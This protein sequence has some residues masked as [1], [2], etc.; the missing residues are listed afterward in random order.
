MDVDSEGDEFFPGDAPGMQLYPPDF[1]PIDLILGA[2]SNREARKNPYRRAFHTMKHIVSPEFLA[3]RTGGGGVT[4]AVKNGVDEEVVRRF[5]SPS[6]MLQSDARDSQEALA[7][8]RLREPFHPFETQG[9][10]AI[11]EWAL[12]SG[13][14]A[15]A[16]SQLMKLASRHGLWSVRSGLSGHQIAS[17]QALIA[18][19]DAGI[20]IHTAQIELR[21]NGRVYGTRRFC[22]IKAEDSLHQMLRDPLFADAMHVGPRVLL[23]SSGDRFISDFSSALLAEELQ[24]EEGPD[25]ALVWLSA[26]SDSSVVN[27]KVSIYP[28]YLSPMN[29]AKEARGKEGAIRLSGFMPSVSANELRNLGVADSRKATVLRGVV[30]QC[31]ALVHKGLTT[32]QPGWAQWPDKRWRLTKGVLVFTKADGKEA[33]C[34]SMTATKC[35]ECNVRNLLDHLC[36]PVGAPPLPL[37]EPRAIFDRLRPLLAEWRNADGTIRWGGQGVLEKG[38]KKAGVRKEWMLGDPA[39]RPTF[40]TPPC[41]MHELGHGMFGTLCRDYCLGL[42]SVYGYGGAMSVCTRLDERGAAHPRCYGIRTANREFWVLMLVKAGGGAHKNGSRKFQ[43][44]EVVELLLLTSDTLRASC[45]PETAALRA[46]VA[47]GTATWNWRDAESAG[48]STDSSAVYDIS[49]DVFPLL[50]QLLHWAMAVK[51]PTVTSPKLQMLLQQTHALQLEYHSVFEMCTPVGAAF[52]K[53][54]R[55]VHFITALLLY[56]PAVGTSTDQEE[57]QHVIFK[58]L[59]WQT[60][61]HA[62][63]DAQ[64]MKRYVLAEKAAEANGSASSQPSHCVT[65]IRSHWPLIEVCSYRPM[66]DSG[67]AA[68]PF[69]IKATLHSPC[70]RDAAHVGIGNALVL[71]TLANRKTHPFSDL[72]PGLWGPTLAAGA[73]PRGS[74][75]N[76]FATKISRF[77]QGEPD[78]ATSAADV[79]PLYKDQIVQHKTLVLTTTAPW[80]KPAALHAHHD[81]YGKRV[82]S[83]VLFRPSADITDVADMWAAHLLFLGKIEHTPEGAIEEAARRGLRMPTRE[84]RSVAYVQWFEE[85]DAAP[86]DAAAPYLPRQFRRNASPGGHQVVDVDKIVGEI[87]MLPDAVAPH[88]DA[89]QAETDVG[90]PRLIPLFRLNWELLHYWG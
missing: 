14:G 63:Y 29:I 72:Y 88:R 58:K 44:N 84:T 20:P 75:A 62:D 73:Q 7:E 55:T 38:E 9:Q 16:A 34:I 65:M 6:M 41:M 52:Q 1:R 15:T 53:M 25:V 77:L 33:D 43:S 81:F 31:Y 89:T 83:Y 13:V 26:Y 64:M 11:T 70:V 79:I 51:M 80:V 60:N 21:A 30:Q 39:S 28:L 12:Q 46:T 22:Y 71:S 3:D 32:Q 82:F 18:R 90:Y 47:A 57:H 54:H 42:I 49:E 59:Y 56:G 4:D 36:A 50:K 48:L 66:S 37:K 87:A 86:E 61:R 78:G 68:H 85:E 17:L 23:S 40:T 69:C 8:A 27:K 35:P 2:A 67:R 19:I 5:A 74:A 76:F 10:Q 45:G 24:R